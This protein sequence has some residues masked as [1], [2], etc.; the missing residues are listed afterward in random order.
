MRIVS[1][2]AVGMVGMAGMAGM[3]SVHENED[4]FLGKV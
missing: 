1:V 2:G 3:V 4:I